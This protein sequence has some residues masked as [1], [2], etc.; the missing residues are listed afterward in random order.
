MIANGK[1]YFATVTHGCNAVLIDE[2]RLTF[3][4]L[5]LSSNLAKQINSNSYSL[6]WCPRILNLINSTFLKLREPFK[7]MMKLMKLLKLTFLSEPI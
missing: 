2:T 1:I 4:H 6:K 5:D 3:D 7:S